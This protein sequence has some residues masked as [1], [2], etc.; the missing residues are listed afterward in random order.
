MDYSELQNKA[1][2]NIIRNAYKLFANNGIHNVALVQI[3]KESEIGVATVYRY[4]GNKKN[5]VN[6]CANSVWKKVILGV[7]DKISSLEF[8]QL[9]GIEKIEGLLSMFLTMYQEDKEFLKFVSEY[10]AYIAQE[11]QTLEE[12]QEYNNNF[13]TFHEIGLNFFDEGIQDKTIKEDIDFDT[14]YYS[15]TRA[16][17]D[18]SMKGANSPVLIE[19]DK[20][21]PIEKQLEQLI[22]IAIFYCKKGE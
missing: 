21:V 10:D 18:V 19:T 14:F 2:E 3:A 8:L 1:K 11:K 12:M 6:E 16:L 7:Q 9:T 13:L 17:L 15:I 20:T 22:T 4:F 5:I